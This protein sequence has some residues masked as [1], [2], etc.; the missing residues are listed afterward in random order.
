MFSCDILSGIRFEQESFFL[1]KRTYFL[2]LLLLA[3]KV[4]FIFLQL[5]CFLFYKELIT[6]LCSYKTIFLHKNFTM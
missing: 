1:Q 3:N 6:H 5:C 2:V 4:T